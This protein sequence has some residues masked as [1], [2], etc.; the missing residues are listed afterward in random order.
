MTQ[1]VFYYS[2]TEGSYGEYNEYI[3]S[4]HI[5]FSSEQFQDMVNSI[6]G[7]EK[8]LHVS[9]L[10]SQMVDKFD[11]KELEFTQGAHIFYYNETEQDKIHFTEE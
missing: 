6:K 5:E 11:F 2:F 3:L 8:W 9:S 4:H 7:E 1:K 10:I